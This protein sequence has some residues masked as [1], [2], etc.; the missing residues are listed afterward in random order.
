MFEL[1]CH[2]LSRY[3]SVVVLT[4]NVLF[5]DSLCREKAWLNE[6]WPDLKRVWRKFSMPIFLWMVLFW[7]I[8]PSLLISVFY[9]FQFLF[10]LYKLIKIN[11]RIYGNYEKESSALVTASC[12]RSGEQNSGSKDSLTK[13]QSGVSEL[14]PTRLCLLGLCFHLCIAQF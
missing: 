13:L 3:E 6:I 5:T 2:R 7:L 10:H 11:Y 9:F 14:F 8:M 12:L 1:I 4:I